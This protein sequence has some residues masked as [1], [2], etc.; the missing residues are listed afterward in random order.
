VPIY[1]EEAAL[2][3]VFIVTPRRFGDERGFFEET[4]SARDLKAEGVI[5]SFVQDNHSFSATVGTLRGLHF[6]APPHA[7]D[8]LVRCTQGAIFDVAVDIRVGSATYGQWV[9]EELS[10]ENGRQLLVPK[11]FLHGFLTLLPNTEVQYKC[12]DYYAPDYDG[13]VRWDSVPVAWP[14]APG[15]V[16]VL[17]QKDALAPEFCDFN[18]PFTYEAP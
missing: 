17:S 8:K 12:T 4:W 9:G 10:R 2:S 6:Q 11:G 18:S 14:L 7:Q 16:P 13:S 3:G 5:L 1:I 15:I